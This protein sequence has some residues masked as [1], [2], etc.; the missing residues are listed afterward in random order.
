[1]Y[2]WFSA[3]AGRIGAPHARRLA[4]I[5]LRLAAIADSTPPSGLRRSVMGLSFPAP[6]GLAAGFDKHGALY[7]TLPR[8]GFGFAEIGSVTPVPEA[9]RSRGLAAVL[10]IL[11]RHSA[12]HAIPLGV[13]I[14]MN[15]ATPPAR[16]ADDYLVCLRAVWPQA[17]YVTLNLGMRAGLDLHRQ[18]HRALLRGVLAAVKEEQARL[19]ITHG[20][21][22]PIAFKVDQTRGDTDALLGYARAFAFD[23]VIL[24]GDA[25]E[26]AQAQ[27]LAMLERAALG[28][29]L[30][31]ISVG[32]IRT[33][34]D[35]RDRLNAGAAL[36]QVFTGLVE[37]GPQFV[38]RINRELAMEEPESRSI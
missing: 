4:A 32:G 34:R 2:R 10:A 17:D 31:I 7:G 18:E 25:V 14:S 16:V 9:G 6:V 11:A 30:P 22:V 8:L 38:R 19:T 33:P 5:S 21:H 26:G 28:S 13:S 35:V 3:L 37:S 36:V 29:R 27:H 20:R 15:R 24:S 12:P 1:M 23:G